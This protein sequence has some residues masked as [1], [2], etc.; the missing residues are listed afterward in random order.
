MPRTGTDM[1]DKEYT[2][3]QKEAADFLHVSTKSI[4]RYRKR[5]LPY[6]LILNPVAGKQEVR[7]CYADLERWHEGRQ[8]LATFA[9]DG[10]EPANTNSNAGADEGRLPDQSVNQTFL[11]DLLA[12]YKEQI[13]LLRDQLEDMREQLGRRDRQIDDLMRLMVGLQLE[14]KPL[15]VAPANAGATIAEEAQRKP[16]I[17]QKMA[18][19]PL[20]ET[21]HVPEHFQLAQ[22]V[23]APP[24]A[25]P[26]PGSGPDK[27]VFSREQLS[28]SILRLRRK[29]K[30]YGEIA[31]GLNRIAAATLSGKQEW[32]ISEVMTLLPALVDTGAPNLLDE[33]GL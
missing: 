24:P 25:T 26:A 3:T 11:A 31:G 21:I 10:G 2:V 29:G 23:T 7:F 17:L 16:D 33:N 30:S 27:K 14:Y 5:G 6:K 13:E 12:A 9:R 18:S 28:A 15:S 32:T 20:F 22:T 1:T 19:G 4:S 8:L